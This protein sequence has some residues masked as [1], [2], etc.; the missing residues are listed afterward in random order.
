MTHTCFVESLCCVGSKGRGAHMGVMQVEFQKPGSADLDL[1]AP[2]PSN[3]GLRI[4]FGAITI[5]Q[6]SR[7]NLEIF[8]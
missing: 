5:L 3:R 1:T 7:K 6:P 8:V 2:P 4:W